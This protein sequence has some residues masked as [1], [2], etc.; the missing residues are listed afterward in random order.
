VLGV[1]PIASAGFLVAMVVKY[2]STAPASQVWSM[3]GIIISGLVM[4]VV[5]RLWLRSPFFAV[6][7]ESDPGQ[8]S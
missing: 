2:L 1:L 7:R 4:L 5:S 3:L 8:A 6:Q